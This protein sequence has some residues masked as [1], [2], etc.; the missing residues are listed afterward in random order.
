MRKKFLTYFTNKSMI[1]L[2]GR[3]SGG[4]DTR[5]ITLPHPAKAGLG[6]LNVITIIN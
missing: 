1:I 5:P 2:S 4:R 6:L 3:S